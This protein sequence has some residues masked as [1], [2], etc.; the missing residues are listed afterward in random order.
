MPGEG[1]PVPGMLA[2]LAACL[3][4][5]AFPRREQPE[6]LP[7][8]QVLGWVSGAHRNKKR[9]LCIRSCCARLFLLQPAGDQSTDDAADDRRDPEQPKRPKCHAAAENGGR[10]RARRVTDALSTGMATRWMKVSVNPM[11][12]GAKPTGAFGNVTLTITMRNSAVRTISI[13]ATCANGKCPSP[14]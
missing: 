7:Q 11:A 1:N 2:G 8:E 12:I 3:V 6:G 13:N 5:V 4:L 9:R 14:P 10:G